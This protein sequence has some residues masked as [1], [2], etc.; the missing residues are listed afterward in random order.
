[1]LLDKV[2]Q[3]KSADRQCDTPRPTEETDDAGQPLSEYS[4]GVADTPYR[5]TE[6]DKSLLRGF[7]RPGR[8]IH[9][10]DGQG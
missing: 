8:R 1:M 2:T 4:T 5:G 10:I 6:T 7:Q 9:G 3:C